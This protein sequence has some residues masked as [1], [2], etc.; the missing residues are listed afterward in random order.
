MNSLSAKYNF[1]KILVFTLIFFAN[2][3]LANKLEILNVAPNFIFSVILC[4]SLVENDSSNIYYS[5]GFG[6]LFDF[7]NGKIMC[8]HAVMFVLITFVL[9][10]FYHTYFEN[11][12]SVKTLFAVIG[13]FMYSLLFAI[14]FGLGDTH[15]FELFFSVS[16]I[17][18]LY[19]SVITIVSIFIYR[20][21]ISIRRSAWRVR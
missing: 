15:F 19:N 2:Q 3:T 9:S 21:I 20:K 10:E 1:I 18:F 12:V 14:F 13:C 5:L 11:M 6:L 16:L 17:E 8:V 4:A 7:F